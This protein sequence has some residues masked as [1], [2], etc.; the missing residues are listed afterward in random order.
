[1]SVLVGIGL[2]LMGVVA[3]AAIG[4]QAHKV[5]LWWNRSVACRTCGFRMLPRRPSGMMVRLEDSPQERT[6]LH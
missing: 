1:M 3:G 6:A 2:G 5:S 4:W